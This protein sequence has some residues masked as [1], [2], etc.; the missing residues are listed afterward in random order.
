M[1]AYQ[2]VWW[3]A[4]GT[5]I[6]QAKNCRSGSVSQSSG[7]DKMSAESALCIR[8]ICAHAREFD[9]STAECQAGYVRSQEA[10]GL[11]LCGHR[12]SE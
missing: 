7:L 2:Y 1:S 3:T 6:R 10:T 8:E 9:F 4:K 12:G 11:C 5:P